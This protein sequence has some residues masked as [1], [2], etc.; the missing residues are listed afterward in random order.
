M[1]SI[2]CINGI[3]G[4]GHMNKMAV[5][6]IYGKNVHKFSYSEPKDGMQHQGLMIYKVK[7]NDDLRLTLTYFTERSHCVA[8]AFKL[9]NH[10][11]YVVI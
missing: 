2:L 9:G 3:N 4:S 6:L 7:I 11:F 1:G 8:Y 5:M 10:I